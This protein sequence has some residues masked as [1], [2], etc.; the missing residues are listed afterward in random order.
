P[1]MRPGRVGPTGSLHAIT[2]ALG[3]DAG[4]ASDTPWR[5]P[6]CGRTPMSRWER[7]KDSR[8]ENHGWTAPESYNVFVADRGA[9]R[10]NF[11]DGWI[12]KPGE[13]SICFHDREPPEDRCCIEV[14]YLRLQP[15]DWSGLPLPE[16]LKSACHGEGG[17]VCG[18]L[19]QT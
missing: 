11:P 18:E 4:T 8:P 12:V 6:G 3:R 9:L 1:G 17:I 16:L 15:I 13:A 10:L 19:G 2:C 5:R 14:S 7:R